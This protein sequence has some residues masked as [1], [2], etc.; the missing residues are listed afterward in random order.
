MLYIL[1][2]YAAPV[3][4]MLTIF[5]LYIRPILEYSCAVWHPAL[6]QH[7]SYQIEKIQ[8]RACRIILGNKYLDYE[9]ALKELNITM[10]SNRRENLMLKFGQDILNSERHRHM[11]PEQ[12]TNTHNL[13]RI[14][15][16]PK[17]LCKTSRYLNSTIPFV[18]DIL[19]ASEPN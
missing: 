1:R 7:Q 5:Q 15:R 12:R 18:I 8:K 3:G 9:S 13:R 17:P 4:D 2:K 6:T 14:N 16:L 10:L 11:L 19:K